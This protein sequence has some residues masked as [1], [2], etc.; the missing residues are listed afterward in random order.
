EGLLGSGYYVHHPTVPIG[1]IVAMMNFD[2][3]GRLRD[4]RLHVIG[5]KSGGALSGLVMDGLD[6]EALDVQLQDAPF[7]ASDHTPFYGAGI[8]VLLFPPGVHDDY[9]SARDP[10]DKTN[11]DGM[12]GVPRVAVRVAERLPSEPRPAYVKLSPPTHDS[13]GRS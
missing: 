10:A 9:H 12:A 3:V 7:A 1:R 11:A 8:P 6:K 5:V 4:R 13:R 2:M